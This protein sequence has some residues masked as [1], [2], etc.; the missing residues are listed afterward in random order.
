MCINSLHDGYGYVNPSSVSSEP[1]RRYRATHPAPS[2]AG[3]RKHTPVRGECIGSDW[4]R[5]SG[6]LSPGNRRGGDPDHPSTSGKRENRAETRPAG[7]LN[8]AKPASYRSSE[9]ALQPGPTRHRPSAEGLRRPRRAEKV[10]TVSSPMRFTAVRRRGTAA[11]GTPP[12]GHPAYHE[13]PSS[14]G[15][16]DATSA[17]REQAALL[18]RDPS[19]QGRHETVHAAPGAFSRRQ[20]RGIPGLRPG[21]GIPRRRTARR[22]SRIRRRRKG[23]PFGDLDFPGT[24]RER[25]RDADAGRSGDRHRGGRREPSRG[26]SAAPPGAEREP[27]PPCDLHLRL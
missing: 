10:E 3:C 6:K 12:P 27:A 24:P 26:G 25:R 15:I 17:G 18:P 9:T 11:P 14:P 8:Q 4:Q 16:T 5:E 13:A 19:S 20:P 21:S 22:R 1:L 7:T 23:V 2:G